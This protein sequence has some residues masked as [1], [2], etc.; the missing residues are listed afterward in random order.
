MNKPVDQFGIN[1]SEYETQRDAFGLWRWIDEN[2]AEM[3]REENFE[4]IYLGVTR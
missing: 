1:T 2:L 3:E 4:T